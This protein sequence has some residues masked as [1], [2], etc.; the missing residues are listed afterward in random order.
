MPLY[1]LLSVMLGYPTNEVIAHLDELEDV[2]MSSTAFSD[3]DQHDFELFFDW[4]KQQSML[5]FQAYYVKTFDLTP[6]NALYLTHHLFEEDDKQRGP[7][8]INLSQHFRS[9]G[10]DISENE[11]PDYLPLILEFVST[12]ET[13]LNAQKFLAQSV[14]ALEIVEQNLTRIDSPY[15]ALMRIVVRH[16]QL[17]NKAA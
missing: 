17:T 12:N 4:A 9:Q 7:T 2:A 11:L 15:A 1:K 8:L 5:D 6:D 3:E 16:G 13:E 10:Y 14:H